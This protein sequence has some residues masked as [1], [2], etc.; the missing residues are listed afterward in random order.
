MK[1]KE[2]KKEVFNSIGQLIAISIVISLGLMVFFCP[3]CFLSLEHLWRL[4]EDFL[5]SFFITLVLMA[6]IQQIIEFNNRHW[7]WIKVPAK[8]LLVDILSVGFYS[9][10]VGI[11]FIIV[12]IGL[13]KGEFPLDKIPWKFISSNAVMPMYISLIIGAFFTSRSFL[14]EWKQ[15][16]IAS[17]QLKRE[18]LQARF[19]SLREQVNPHFLFNSFNV[20]TDLIHTD[21]DKAKDFVQELSRVFRYV[22]EASHQETATLKDELEFV[23]SYVYLLKMRYGENL[24]LVLPEEVPKV[25]IL[26]LTLQMLVENAIKHNVIAKEEPLKIEIKVQDQ[27]VSVSNNIQLKNTRDESLGIGLNNIKSRYELL[28]NQSINIDDSD[29]HYTVTLPYINPQK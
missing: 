7:P 18:N 13:I 29:G 21:Q 28:G 4:R 19:N 16:A 9:F 15:A 11:L 10:I 5:Y 27:A 2:A 25:E 3:K 14:I 23:K 8:R 1:T 20:L 26:P 17:E 6:G 24:S 12:F 22:L